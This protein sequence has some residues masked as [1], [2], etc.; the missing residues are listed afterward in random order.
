MGGE[1]E[2]ER[3]EGVDRRTG[4]ARDRDVRQEDRHSLFRHRLGKLALNNHITQ[5]IR[6]AGL[7]PGDAIHRVLVRQKV[8]PRVE[9]DLRGDNRVI[10]LANERS[11]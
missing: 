8:G 3:G 6:R 2:W 1:S 7:L 11:A 9:F 5:G 10:A 4:S